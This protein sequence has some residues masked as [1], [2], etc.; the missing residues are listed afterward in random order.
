M[1]SALCTSCQLHVFNAFHIFLT[2][3]ASKRSLLA[4]FR[5][6]ETMLFIWHLSPL[7]GISQS[8][9]SRDTPTHLVFRLLASCVVPRLRPLNIN[10]LLHCWHFSKIWTCHLHLM[11]SSSLLSVRSALC[12][13][14]L[15][16]AGFCSPRRPS[17]YW[18]HPTDPKSVAGL[19]GAWTSGSY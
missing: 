2:A 17:G 12:R 5:S 15:P 7:L 8:V 9:R 3:C 6:L 13:Y 4:C 14:F 18:S 1:S 11:L 10:R 16:P 19:A